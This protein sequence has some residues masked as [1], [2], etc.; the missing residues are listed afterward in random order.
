MRYAK[1]HHHISQYDTEEKKEQRRLIAE[2]P[3]DEQRYFREHWDGG[4]RT[5]TFTAI[6]HYGK[7][8]KVKPWWGP[9]GEL[10][11]MDCEPSGMIGGTSP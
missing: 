8:W 9:G 3:E 7:K 4:A 10:E 5:D 6:K 2:L 1:A 11:K